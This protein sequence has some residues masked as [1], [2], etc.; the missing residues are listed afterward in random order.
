MVNYWL[1]VIHSVENW[2]KV[3][4]NLVWGGGDRWHRT[5][6]R[7]KANDGLVFYLSKKGFVGIF[8]AASEYFYD[9][10][11]IWT[12]KIYPHRIKLTPL[13]IPENPIALNEFLKHFNKKLQAYVRMGVRRIQEHEF[14]FIKNQLFRVS[15]EIEVKAVKP[16]DEYLEHATKLI[17]KYP[18]MS[19]ANTISQL[20]E[21]LLEILGWNTRN[22]D[23]VEKEYPIP[24]GKGDEFVDIALKID[25]MPKVFIEAKALATDLKDY[26]VQQLLN[27]AL[28][29]NVN[30]CIVT[31]GRELR[32]YNAFWK[33]VGIEQRLFL[34]LTINEYK[35]KFNKLQLLSKES[36]I[37]N[38]LDK[39]SE[40]AY[41]KRIISEWFKQNESSVLSDIAKLDP[42][43]T[44][45][46][47]KG[48]L[49]KIL[50]PL[51]S[52]EMV[53]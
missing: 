20:I 1:C 47:I 10:T 38:T 19:E 48:I 9:E 14:L 34:R 22:L 44:K 15:K 53:M 6:G 24:G 21:P 35:E 41:T 8:V 37:N 26:L 18:R 46:T 4:E 17:T 28:L 49:S 23:E 50:Q 3:K 40:L 25:D 12:D 30:W 29:G 45:E 27:Y 7:I 43:L 51:E 2:N 31:N 11:K 5:V 52:D 16:I 42:S 36:I 33:V 39:E 13:S 32:V